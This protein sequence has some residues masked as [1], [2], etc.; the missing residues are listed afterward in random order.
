MTAPGDIRLVMLDEARLEAIR[1]GEPEAGLQHF[2]AAIAGQQLDLY[3]RSGAFEPWLGYAAFSTADERLVGSCS[4]VGPPSGGEVEIAYY[5]FAGFEG[6]GFGSAMAAALVRIAAAR[7]EV[8][9]VAA[10]TLPE[11]NSSTSILRKLGFERDG[12]VIDREAGEV[13]RWRLDLPRRGD[14]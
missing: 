7:D 3:R 8:A 14:S 11:D 1:A 5:T 9:T 2:P 6:R 4:F 13:W 12:T 10:K